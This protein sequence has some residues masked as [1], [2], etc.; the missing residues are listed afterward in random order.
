[1]NAP[2]RNGAT[3][4]FSSDRPH[5]DVV[6][7]GRI[8]QPI[9][10]DSG[11][12][13]SMIPKSLTQRLE[14]DMGESLA[15]SS[16]PEDPKS[17]QLTTVTGAPIKVQRKV[18]VPIS[19]GNTTLNVPMAEIDSKEV[20]KPILG[21]NF[22]NVAFK[23]MH[24]ASDGQVSVE[25]WDG[26]SHACRMGK[27]TRT[28]AA[29]GYVNV[30][31]GTVVQ[32]E[33][34]IPAC[35][36]KTDIED[37]GKA[38]HV[39]VKDDYKRLHD[40]LCIDQISRTSRKG[41]IKVL[42]ANNS[43]ID[44]LICEDEEI[45]EISFPDYEFNDLTA[46]P[47]YVDEANMETPMH[48]LTKIGC[49]CSYKMSIHILDG[50]GFTSFG[51]NQVMQDQDLRGP[52]REHV[53]T[54]RT[55]GDSFKI[56]VLNNGDR[57][58]RPM[59]I[60]LQEELVHLKKY[61]AIPQDD[62]RILVLAPHITKYT[63]E[64][65][66][67][68]RTATLARGLEPIFAYPD[69]KMK[70]ETCE[71]CFFNR[72]M[73]QVDR[74]ETVRVPNVYIAIPNR[75]GDIDE[76]YF[77]DRTE[78]NEQGC[79]SIPTGQVTWS[80]LNR[81]S[82]FFVIHHPDVWLNFRKLN[83]ALMSTIAS[84]KPCFPR[85]KVT[86]LTSEPKH[87]GLVTETIAASVK[88]CLQR[89][90]LI[91]AELRPGELNPMKL[92]DL[93]PP[94]IGR[95]QMRLKN[96][97]C[98]LCRKDTPNE[99]KVLELGKYKMKVQPYM[100]QTF[101]GRDFVKDNHSEVSSTVSTVESENH[102]ANGQSLPNH[103]LKS[104]T[105]TES[106]DGAIRRGDSTEQSS[107]DWPSEEDFFNIS[108]REFQRIAFA[109]ISQ[110]KHEIK[111]D[112][113]NDLN[114]D[115]L[116][117]LFAAEIQKEISDEQPK[118]YVDHTPDD[119]SDAPVVYRKSFDEEMAP[120]LKSLEDDETFD[121]IP[122]AAW[123]KDNDYG[124][125]MDHIDLEH[126]EPE[127]IP[128]IEKL[129]KKF[130]DN[131]I[132]FNK[133]DHSV[134]IGHWLRLKIKFDGVHFAKPIPYNADSLDVLKGLIKHQ[135]STGIITEID[136]LH[137]SSAIFLVPHNSQEKQKLMDYNRQR[138]NGVKIAPLSDEELA[139][140][141]IGTHR[142]NHV[143]YRLIYDAVKLNT[144]ICPVPGDQLIQGTQLSI[145]N[146]A[147]AEMMSLIDA[148]GAFT[149]LPVGVKSRAW[150][151][152]SMMDPRL[153]CFCF[154]PL[155]I[156]TIPS[157]YSRVL[158]GAVRPEVR[159][160]CRFHLD[161]IILC[162]SRAI[163]P[164]LLEMLFEDLLAV[165]MLVEA[166]K[167]KL[168][169]TEVT[170]LGFRINGKTQR[171]TQ[172]SHDTEIEIPRTKAMLAAF[173]G[174]M[175]YFSHFISGFQ[176]LAAL[177]H[178]LLK[179]QTKFEP[180]DLQIRAMEEIKRL[181]LKAPSLWLLDTTLPLYVATDSSSFGSGAVFFQKAEDGDRT[182]CFHSSKYSRSVQAN[183]SSLELELY[184]ILKTLG[185]HRHLITRGM[186]II[187][188]TDCRV[189]T[190]LRA[191]SGCISNSKLS[192]WFSCL[193]SMAP[194]LTVQ[195][196][197]SS[198]PY[199]AL[200]DYFSRAGEHHIRFSNRRI[201]NLQTKNKLHAKVRE[202]ME[203]W[204]IDSR[205]MTHQELK[206]L[207]DIVGKS[208][209]FQDLLDALKKVSDQPIFPHQGQHQ[210]L[211]G[212][213]TTE[214]DNDNN[215]DNME[216][217][218]KEDNEFAYDI[219]VL[220]EERKTAILHEEHCS[221]VGNIESEPPPD[222]IAYVDSSLLCV[223][224]GDVDEEIDNTCVLIDQC[225]AFGDQ[226]SKG[227]VDGVLPLTYERISK[228]QGLD[229]R[230][231]SII[232]KVSKEK[233]YSKLKKR[234]MMHGGLLHKVPHGGIGDPKPYLPEK[235]V[236]ETM[237]LLHAY[238]GH[239]GVRSLMTRFKVHYSGGRME[240]F[241]QVVTRGCY[242]CKAVRAPTGR[243][244]L[245]GHIPLGTGWGSVWVMDHIQMPPSIIG[246][247]N[248]K[249]MLNIM[250]LATRFSMGRPV[251]STKGNETIKLVKELISIVGRVNLIRTDGG[252]GL[253]GST[254]FLQFCRSMG[255]AVRTG[256]P[257]RPTAH[258]Q[259][260]VSNHIVKVGLLAHQKAYGL[261]WPAVYWLNN[262]ALN[263]TPRKYNIIDPSDGESRIVEVSP[264]Q[265]VFGL[266]APLIS[267][268]KPHETRD[269]YLIQEKIKIGIKAYA[270]KINAEREKKDK[271]HKEGFGVG[272]L[273]L[274]KSNNRAMVRTKQWCFP[275]I[276]EVTKRLHRMIEV[277]LFL[278]NTHT[279]GTRRVHISECKPFTTLEELKI[280]PEPLAR[281]F[282]P[283]CRPTVVPNELKVRFRSKNFIR[284]LDTDDEDKMADKSS[285]TNSSET[286]TTDDEIDRPPPLPRRNR[287][288]PPGV[289]IRL[290]VESMDM[291]N[292]LT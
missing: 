48:D 254:E 21:F 64:I 146:V 241:S 106:S 260:E 32:T 78:Q 158:I 93:S 140:A 27:G 7:G 221:Q 178:P 98:Y 183:C 71:K 262:S 155:G 150:L 61:N 205:A 133:K 36:K 245:P 68:I 191:L 82:Y 255:I 115:E 3:I 209:Q 284:I 11:A 246:G 289:D 24:M 33:L 144:I 264:H 15:L 109:A 58:F 142:I 44:T 73:A 199:I 177:L 250:D 54:R 19:I 152:I 164:K 123:S 283:I 275:S 26:N 104:T 28:V 20:D 105:S 184:A 192:R 240:R 116:P 243:D 248:Y 274:L 291:I 77:G 161:D 63:A 176:Q 253:G 179:A 259:A 233:G 190:C 13:L 91:E 34:Y 6:I 162:S 22:I 132:S 38:V 39:E 232:R 279:K 187:V 118:L 84:I 268:A 215:D 122:K 271:E 227:E 214:R 101:N 4:G 242:S 81:N 286:I 57:E 51:D 10:L 89:S 1:M 156:K 193:E 113:I 231:S 136:T 5:L 267:A 135:I 45:A 117:T 50:S 112:A 249:Y 92:K 204:K 208:P 67:Y 42:I 238:Y 276:F 16:D 2:I 182:I 194:A 72:F 278:G 265:V 171:I 196:T 203:N 169:K 131:L 86:L 210:E 228:E 12:S 17:I 166:K 239:V 202:L 153:L 74:S 96:C 9:L 218:L 79:F 185:S 141:P 180:N 100:L 145:T 40:G 102:L 143:R 157:V 272:D 108:D 149:S 121:S 137:F 130:S 52:L 263:H 280:L 235:L 236:L 14:Q 197:S 290:P 95:I 216:D 49:L 29:V 127:D 266:S 172:E 168:L 285:I 167:L 94:T 125:P 163:H 181:F 186:P 30:P 151:G 66:Y 188:L 41:K 148:K 282:G 76:S 217:I 212:N 47:L 107:N 154:A 25:M 219:Q 138:A 257:N 59:C 159:K 35:G 252:P 160:Y 230:I 201:I 87:R 258:G 99:A 247:R 237:A 134:I 234:Y 23:S 244:V 56:G 55:G 53:I 60:K 225:A 270:E 80:R 195:W 69:E 288:P 110:P 251:V 37:Y 126:T 200:A 277:R 220:S 103:D 70:K 213:K 139:N 8:S 43:L 198:D 281:R 128:V 175:N 62:N 88:Y 111:I 287:T 165:G 65:I 90:E 83:L 211:S 173:L 124:N 261:P 207:A 273:V 120:H 292:V 226:L 18:I 189:L 222:N 75:E 147:K 170:Y 269:T 224:R 114:G 229:E 97:S 46:E 119:T 223:D 256:V 85:T 31:A 174:R 129:V 206:E